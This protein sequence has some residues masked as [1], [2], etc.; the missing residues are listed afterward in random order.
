M[1]QTNNNSLYILEQ[2]AKL[3][4]NRD[5]ISFNELPEN[6]IS[7]IAP[8]WDSK[9]Q[10][11]SWSAIQAGVHSWQYFINPELINSD[12]E[13]NKWNGTPSNSSKAELTNSNFLTCYPNPT[14]SGGII[15]GFAPILINGNNQIRIYNSIGQLI[16]SKTL[17]KEQFQITVQL[18]AK[19]LYFIALY[20]NNT[21]LKHQKWVVQ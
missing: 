12:T 20:Q 11:S 17:V 5:A 8:Y 13:N 16:S 15:E 9:P 1:K 10:Q 18:P 3:L 7:A 19:G 21:L 6:I 4:M 14:N 2:E